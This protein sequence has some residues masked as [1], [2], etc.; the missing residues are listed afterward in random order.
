MGVDL[1]FIINT[2][3]FM[4]FLK[5]C[6]VG[7]LVKDLIIWGQNDC[8]F[9]KFSD[10]HLTMYGEV[11]EKNV[12][13]KIEGSI[14]IVVLD[15]VIQ[16]LSRAE[17]EIIRVVSNTNMFMITDG[18]KAGKF[19][20][21]FV[22]SGEAEFVNSYNKIKDAPK[23]IFQKDSLQY[24]NFNFE[25]GFEIPYESLQ[26]ILKDAKAF[27]FESYKFKEDKNKD[28][29]S[30]LSCVIEDRSIGEKFTRK[31]IINKK[32]TDV[33]MKPVLIGTGFK[34]MIS[35]LDKEIEIKGD[36]KNKLLKN[37]KLYFHDVAVLI[38]DGIDVFYIIN[39]IQEN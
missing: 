4:D 16:V 30:I 9:S 38:T 28:G 32:F 7:G 23:T 14:K 35:S 10:Q 18:D 39:S 6:R 3:I 13:I 22:Q 15:K 19:R 36:D 31:M 1:D 20:S 34:E 29:V 33:D 8:I 5:K 24:K 26:T 2:K 17:S 27:G 37:Y 21:E 11:Y 25:N 12:K